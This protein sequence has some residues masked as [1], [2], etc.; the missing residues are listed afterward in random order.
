MVA[1]PISDDKGE[2]QER[3]LQEQ[4]E[5]GDILQPSIED[6]HRKL[7]YKNLAG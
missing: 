2:V 6:G 3:L 4:A 1:Q 5:F 7:G